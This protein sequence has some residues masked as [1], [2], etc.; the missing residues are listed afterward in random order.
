[1]AETWR[2][3]TTTALR[4]KLSVEESLEGWVTSI[5]RGMIWLDAPGMGVQH[6]AQARM[7]GPQKPWKLQGD[8][9]QRSRNPWGPGGRML[10]WG[11]ARAT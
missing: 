10:W 4:Q 2:K 8:R 7:G 5:P 6:F 3:C 9:R 1:V 11:P